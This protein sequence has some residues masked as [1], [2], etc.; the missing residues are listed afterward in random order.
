MQLA[1]LAGQDNLATLRGFCGEGQNLTESTFKFSDACPYFGLPSLQEA[2]K[3]L[4]EIKTYGLRRVESRQMARIISNPGFPLK[5]KVPHAE[6][7]LLQSL[8]ATCQMA[9]PP[10]LLP[11]TDGSRIA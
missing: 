7:F 6:E 4:F 3:Y 9:F 8:R 1:G 2:S 5:E 11:L 10:D